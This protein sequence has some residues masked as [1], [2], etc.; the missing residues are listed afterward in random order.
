MSDRTIALDA[1]VDKSV[2]LVG[3]VDKSV[4]LVGQVEGFDIGAVPIGRP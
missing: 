2:A 1:T 3:T 4:A